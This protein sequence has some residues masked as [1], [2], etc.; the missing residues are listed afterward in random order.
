MPLEDVILR[1][2]SMGIEEPTNFP[3]PTPPNQSDLT[4]AYALLS[5]IG[6]VELRPSTTSSS[7]NGSSNK[8]V[9]TK[10]GRA[11]ASFP[12]GARYAKMLVLGRQAGVLDYVTALV[13]VL[14]E[15]DPLV[16]PVGEGKEEKEGGVDGEEEELLK[17]QIEV[18]NVSYVFV[19]SVDR[20]LLYID[21]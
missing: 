13:A 7:T 4:S 5:Y 8:K 3:F 17:K 2:I 10:L 6:A 14:A 20:R 11:I 19:F 12:I 21:T 18:R 9:I 15:R 1:M 16:F